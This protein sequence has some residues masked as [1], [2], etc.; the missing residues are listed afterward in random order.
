MYYIYI[1]QHGKP[2]FAPSTGRS[3]LD[4]A[5]YEAKHHQYAGEYNSLEEFRK[6][7][8]SPDED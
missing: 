1:N 5:V 4:Q 6:D 3:E 8:Y 2:P 7:L